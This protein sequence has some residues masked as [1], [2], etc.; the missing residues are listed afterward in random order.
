[1]LPL[2]VDHLAERGA[3]AQFSVGERVTHSVFGQGTVEAV[4][5]TKRAYV[6]AFDDLETSRAISFRTPLQKTE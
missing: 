6:V 3:A 5:M 2:A 4:D 1:M